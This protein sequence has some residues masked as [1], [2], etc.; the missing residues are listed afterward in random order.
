MDLFMHASIAHG[1]V[2]NKEEKIAHNDLVAH[3]N[4]HRYV[5]A[6]NTD[7]FFKHITRDISFTLVVDDFRIKY[8]NN[9]DVQH[10]IRIMQE[11]YTFKVDFNAKQ[12][13]DIDLK[14]DYD[15]QELICSMI[16]CV[17]QA[18]KELEHFPSNRHQSAPSHAL[19]KQYGEK[20]QYVQ[21]DETA[22]LTE[23]QICYLQRVIRK[24]L[25]YAQAIDNT[26]LH[27]LNDI[28][29]CSTKGTTAT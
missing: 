5:Q 11:I 4:K 8:V 27:D 26:M 2:S 10:L 20:V 13:I 12:Y 21:D 25:W 22:P 19:G 28:G 23:I 29:S 3:L 14:W 7:G 18:L 17:K 6:D 1:T 9:D 24:F 16:G 15:K